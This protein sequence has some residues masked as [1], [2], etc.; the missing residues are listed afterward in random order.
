MDIRREILRNVIL[1]QSLEPLGKK[2]GRVAR[3]QGAP[4][5]KLE[6]FILAA[7]NSSWSFYDLADRILEAGKQPDSIFDTAYE[8]QNAS[9]RSRF[10]GKVNYGQTY[11][12]VPLITAQVLHFLET[13]D[14]D[15]VESVLRRSAD[16]LRDTTEKDVEYL[17]KFVHLGYQQSAR[18]RERIGKPKPPRFPKF[19][20]KYSNILDASR[21]YTHIHTVREVADGYPHCER[22][23]RFLLHN[24]EEGLLPSSDL[25][26]QL[27]LPELQRPDAAADMIAVGMYLVLSQHPETALFL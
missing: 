12:L 27:L 11:M 22:V 4:G 19:T 18:H 5:T 7:V 16:V 15:D 21:D 1:C 23:Y 20:G 2:P 8:A 26:Y 24:V 9:V 13:G 14:T 17:E 6:Y 25:I 10:G 3:E